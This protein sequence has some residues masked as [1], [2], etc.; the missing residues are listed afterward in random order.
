MPRRM[1]RC[2]AERMGSAGGPAGGG[3]VQ[4]SAGPRDVRI[5]GGSTIAL[6][7]FPDDPRLWRDIS[8][9]ADRMGPDEVADP[10]RL[11]SA[12]ETALRAWYPRLT[13]HTRTDIAALMP[14]DEVWYVMRD[15]RVGRPD[16]RI[17]RL[18]AALATA[19]DITEEADA[20]LSRSHQIAATIGSTRGSRRGSAAATLERPAT[21]DGDTDADDGDPE[22]A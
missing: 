1:M 13:I 20:A 17:D 11:R 5:P 8:R 16:E 12:I 4:S 14:S 10:E 19:R 7:V 15:G 22:L 6:H 21:A 18:H 3:A 2:M 9:V